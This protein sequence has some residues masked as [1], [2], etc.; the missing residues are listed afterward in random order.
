MERRVPN[1]FYKNRQILI[2]KIY[3]LAAALGTHFSVFAAG[4][5][6]RLFHRFF[7]HKTTLWWR[8][9]HKPPHSRDKGGHF[10]QKRVRSA[11]YNSQSC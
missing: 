10:T 7:R 9:W 1:F 8:T 11:K 6:P 4:V 3:Y 5:M 2:A